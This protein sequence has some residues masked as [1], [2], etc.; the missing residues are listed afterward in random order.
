MDKNYLI[1]NSGSASRK[2]ALFAGDTEAFTAHLEREGSGFVATLSSED[3]RETRALAREEYDASLSFVCAELSARGLLKS[4]SELSGIGVRIVA[5]GA[6]FLRHAVIDDAYLARLEKARAA[7]PLHLDPILAEIKQARLLA[8]DARMVGVSDSAFHATLPEAARTYGLPRESSAE[9]GL[10]RYGYHGLSMRSVT[11]ALEETGG[12][13][14]RVII[15]HLGSGVTVTALAN[16]ASADTSMGFSPLE[17]VVMATRVGS[18]D[19]GAMLYFQERSGMTNA[20]FLTFLNTECGLRGISGATGDVRELL[21]REARGDTAAGL[22]L[23][24]F[25][26]GVKKYIGAYV[27]AL[28]GLDMLVFTAT[29]GERSASMRARIAEGLGALGIR[30][31]AEKNATA[32]NGGGLISPEGADVAVRVVPADET[33]EIALAT[34]AAL[35]S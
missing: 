9:Y 34:R 32:T 27:A 7:A 15:C 3:A 16:G 29:I 12:V 25:V 14:P 1:I 2:Y 26:Y 4:L 10:Y 18:I 11:R 19:A 33:R 20:E 31:D 22:A 8:P 23:S 35:E 24:V 13:P 5:P 21:T 28:G 6:D 30:V 17:G